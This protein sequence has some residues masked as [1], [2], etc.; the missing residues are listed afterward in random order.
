MLSLLK[1]FWNTTPL[2]T[3]LGLTMQVGALGASVLSW[4]EL[5]LLLWGAGIGSALIGLDFQRFTGPLQY[6]AAFVGNTLFAL[7]LPYPWEARLLLALPALLL[8]AVALTV[9]QRFMHIF[10]YTRYLWVEP[11]LLGL[12]LSLG[13]F[14]LDDRQMALGCIYRCNTRYSPLRRVHTRRPLHSYRGDRRVRR[15]S[16][17]PRPRF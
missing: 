12:G 4:T 17:R 8:F 5:P 3:Y 10:T 7:A 2:F 16:R 15:Q 11:L 14:R 1:R 9:R 13:L 6:A